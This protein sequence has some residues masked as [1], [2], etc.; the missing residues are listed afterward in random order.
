MDVD[1]RNTK[2]DPR[3]TIEISDKHARADVLGTTDPTGGKQL[4]E[5]FFMKYG[6]R[7][8]KETAGLGVGMTLG[9]S[10]GWRWRCSE[11]EYARD[12][13]R[14]E[15]RELFKRMLADGRPSPILTSLFVGLAYRGCSDTDE[16]H[17]IR[18]P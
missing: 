5:S 8:E 9:T 15:G 11:Q 12:S 14:N 2:I 3:G 7:G 6:V 18:M 1:A 4:S 16:A 17:R 10:G 13:R